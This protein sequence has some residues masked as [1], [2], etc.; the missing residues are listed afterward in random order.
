[1][2]MLKVLNKTELLMS[3]S[4]RAREKRKTAV[5]IDVSKC[6]LERDFLM[7]SKAATL[8]LL[9][10]EGECLVIWWTSHQLGL[11]SGVLKFTFLT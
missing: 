11:K 8:S 7:I 1:M 4:G 9:S 2:M 3:I 6:G 5:G 10:G